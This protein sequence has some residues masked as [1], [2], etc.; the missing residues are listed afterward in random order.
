MPDT[1]HILTLVSSLCAAGA[2][3]L[4]RQGLR[5][6][7]TYTGFWINLVVGTIGLWCAVGLMA[8]VG[9]V[10]ARAVA[11]FV[12]AGLI[13]TVA[14]RLLRFVSIERVGASVSAAVMSLHPF[15]AT[16]L[17]IL[18]L[19]ERVTAPIVA[20]TGVIVLGTIL[21]SASGR[22]V[23][24]EAGQLTLPFLSATCF[25]IVAVL[26]KVAL[27]Q[28]GPVL[29]FAINVT[30]A[31]AAFTVFLL[32]SGNR[33]AMTSRGRSLGYFIAAGVA[34]NAA[35]FLGLVALNLGTVSVVAPLSSTA[36]IFVLVMSF[37]FLR[38]VEKLSGR[39]VLGTLLIVL[40]VYLITA[41]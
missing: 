17:A 36:P 22:H 37:F 6:G 12:L 13:G 29:G 15:I 34:E 20:G 39:V 14:G 21:L 27:G 31:L 18:L 3:V 30:T 9:P 33:Q 7:D 1:V 23:G 24:F 8:P 25:G 16:G 26:R 4:I 10:S 28:M 41:L 35:V 38:G 32:A 5:G 2:T 11:F 19:G 40:G